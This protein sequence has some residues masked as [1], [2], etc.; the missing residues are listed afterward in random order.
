MALTKPI[1]LS[2]ASWD[3]ANGC[4]FMFDVSGGDQVA[5]NTLT[6]RDNATNEV[7]FTQTVTSFAYRNIV[8]PNA[9]GLQNGVYY[10]AYIETIN[11]NGDVSSK[12]NVIQFYCYE[13]PNVSIKNIVD[14]GRVYTSSPIIQASYS[15]ASGEL[16]RSYE[17]NLYNDA[18][19]KVDSSG[20]VNVSSD[21][22]YTE[23]SYK[24]VGL[25]DNTTYS[26]EVIFNTVNNVIAST[27][28]VNFTVFFD[29]PQTYADLTLVNNC[30]GGYITIGANVSLIEGH[31]N[32]VP[33]IDYIDGTK[34]NLKGGKYVR[35]ENGYKVDDNATWKIWF[36]YP[37]VDATILEW[38][39]GSDTCKLDCILY[40]DDI[41]QIMY[42]LMVSSGFRTYYVIYSDPIETPTQSTEQCIQVRN[43]DNLYD[44]VWEAIE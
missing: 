32:L 36:E 29:S 39:N 26:V 38:T 35:W 40:P 23:V 34:V 14:G 18:G 30:E 44:L 9:V 37:D 28:R 20:V 11:I 3:V 5:G 27:G 41:T 43:I 2:V 1:L 16:L 7:V 6:I 24:F 22:I 25:S 21:S 10:N 4:T 31:T 15:Q 12:S 13:T 17:F 8:P 42:R 19:R 33:P